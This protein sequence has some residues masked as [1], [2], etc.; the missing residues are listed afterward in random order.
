[1]YATLFRVLGQVPEEFKQ[2]ED[3]KYLMSVAR[4]SVHHLVNLVYPA[5]E[6]R[7]RVKRRRIFPPVH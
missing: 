4:R 3:A 1:M 5:D 7:R 6:S 2:G